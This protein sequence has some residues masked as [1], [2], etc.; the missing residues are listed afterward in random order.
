MRSVVFPAF[1]V[2]SVLLALEIAVRVVIPQSLIRVPAVLWKRD[3]QIGWRHHPNFE[4]RVNASGRDVR[5]CTDAEGDRI[6]CDADANRECKHRILV[7]GD[8]FVEALAV[9]YR[10]TVWSRIERDTGACAD[11]AGVAGYA[12][13]QYVMSAR[14]R[15]ADPTVHYDLVILNFFSGNDFTRD[16]TMIPS[17]FSLTL[18]QASLEAEYYGLP[19]ASALARSASSVNRWLGAHSHAYVATRLAVRRVRSMADYYGP[20]SKA[21]RRS[22]LR[23]KIVEATSGGIASVAADAAR[24]G[25]PLIV[26]IIPHPNQV[27]DPR[28]ERFV[29]LFPRFA[30]DVDM[31]IVAKRFVPVIQ[32]IP[33]VEVIDLL[34][35]L[36]E[37]ADADAWSLDG[38]FSSKGH[39]LWFE[40]VRDRVRKRLASESRAPSH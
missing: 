15:L 5:I 22:T 40:E 26:V 19:N 39:E 2:V 32:Q 20:R 29:N 34:P 17:V 31:D 28:G 4:T 12:V 7:I 16:A 37:Y 11:V 27:L 35:A 36:R 24:A 33:N 30:D 21:L 9:P 1:F 14:T 18:L 23:K 10:D 6:D 8:S 3:P 38:H 13:S 25:S